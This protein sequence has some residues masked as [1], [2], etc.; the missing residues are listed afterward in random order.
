MLVVLVVARVMGHV[1]RAARAAAEPS[2]VV[3]LSVVDLG[4]IVREVLVHFFVHVVIKF[5]RRRRRRRLGRRVVFGFLE[6]RIFPETGDARVH[7]LWIVFF[8]VLVDHTLVLF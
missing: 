6:V 1:G 5:S 8:G 2:S 7:A 3:T 4:G